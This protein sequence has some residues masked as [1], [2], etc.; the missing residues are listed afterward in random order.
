MSPVAKA[1]ALL[2]V[3]GAK[4]RRNVTLRAT[5]ASTVEA[6]NRTESGQPRRTEVLFDA[7]DLEIYRVSISRARWAFRL[8]ALAIVILALAIVGAL[9]IIQN[10]RVSTEGSVSFDGYQVVTG[11]DSSNAI[12]IVIGLATIV[13]ALSIALGQGG[14]EQRHVNAFATESVW[15][16]QIANA[17][18]L[19]SVTALAT[20]LTQ[21]FA[22]GPREPGLVITV[23]AIGLV[24]VVIASS[25]TTWTGAEFQGTLEMQ[26]ELSHLREDLP[27]LRARVQRLAN[28]ERTITFRDYTAFLAI[29]S[30]LTP[31]I[32]LL[33][34][35]AAGANVRWSPI[36]L[37]IPVVSAVLTWGV[38]ETTI[39]ARIGRMR[40]PT[41]RRWSRFPRVMCV[42]MMTTVFAGVA[43][44]T[45]SA[46]VYG[47]MT[48]WWTSALAIPGIW[49][50]LAKR[51]RRGPAKFALVRQL[52]AA[53]RQ[54]VELEKGLEE[55]RES[56]DRQMFRAVRA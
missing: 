52:R 16:D 9:E 30:L 7:L 1:V 29:T 32:L 54:R 3:L 27:K 31:V 55:P 22:P 11:I 19:A 50:F 49:L 6:C 48:M 36:L 18:A 53:E 38:V 8:K 28:S 56:T 43:L 47:L 4:A 12:V 51:W 25:V 42:S 17:S 24:S 39:I 33:Y 46:F 20:G 21:L 23:L 14:V 2:L 37:L 41:A 15:A 44:E 26:D 5:Q 45:R 13:A 10:L 35:F 40:G 34:G